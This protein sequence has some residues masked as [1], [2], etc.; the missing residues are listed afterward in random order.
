MFV[1]LGALGV[2]PGTS[3]VPK[4]MAHIPLLKNTFHKAPKAALG[5]IGTSPWG[6]DS[7][8]GYKV[9]TS[10]LLGLDLHYGSAS[11][12][13]PELRRPASSESEIVAS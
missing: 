2:G 13:G 10:Q 11:T 7:T 6:R 1:L 12:S 8:N 9:S 3:E 5:D 4:L